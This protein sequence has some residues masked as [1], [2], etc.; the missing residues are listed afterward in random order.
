MAKSK[1]KIVDDDEQ[2]I[3]VINKESETEFTPEDVAVMQM[4]EE[5]GGE[6]TARVRIYRQGKTYADITLIHECSPAEFDPMILAHPPYNG[7]E[8]RIHVRS[9]GGMVCNRLLKVA[10]GPNAILPGQMP[11]QQTQQREEIAPILRE[12]MS[13]FQA[14]MLQ[15]ITAMKPAEKDPLQTLEGIER[16]AKVMIPATPPPER[17]MF[18]QTMKAMETF[19]S[20]QER[21]KPEKITDADGE[22]SMPA[23]LLSMVKEFRNMNNAQRNPAIPELPK[24]AENPSGLNEN[25]LTPAQQEEV[26]EMHIVLS[27]QL[28]QANKAAA[29]KTDP[30]EYA[31]GVYSVIPDDVLQM[32]ATNPEWFAEL[33][34]IAPSVAP[35]EAWYRAIAEKLKLM[36]I[37]DGI[38]TMPSATADNPANG[39]VNA[40]TGIKS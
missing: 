19:M 17:D 15:A 28:K 32:I 9:K 34:K 13:G 22:I 33:V 12:M 39:D 4:I 6:A 1:A 21:L 35:F 2:E 7:G 31:E 3:E 20:F 18:G 8:F 29:A 37:E 30:A 38:L 10:P 24:P 27:Y 25:G 40:G 23:V 14:T 5:L 16:L 26:D 36:M 11:M